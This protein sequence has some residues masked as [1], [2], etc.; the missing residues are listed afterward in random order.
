MAKAKVQGC[1]RCTRARDEIA[2]LQERIAEL[3]SE[4]AKAKKNSRNS[5]KPPSTDITSPPCDKNSQG[6]N[7]NAKR[8]RGGQP[9]HPRHERPLFPPE[10]EDVL[11]YRDLD[12]P[13]CGG[14]LQDADLSAR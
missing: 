13:C 2:S 9:G 10:D 11:A 8:K 1:P 12:C 7:N 4:I 5:S 6:K 3:E 14:E